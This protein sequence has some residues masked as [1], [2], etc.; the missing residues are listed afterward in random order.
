[1]GLFEQAN[2][3]NPLPERQEELAILVHGTFSD[4]ESDS[5]DQWWQ[6]GSQEFLELQRRLPGNVRIATDQNVFHWSGENSERARSKAAIELLE[7]LRPLERAGRAYHLVG[8]SHGGSVIWNALR[9]TTLSRKQLRGLRSWTTV[10]TPFLHQRGRGPW[11]PINLL[12]VLFGLA[13]VRPAF[14]ALH[15]LSTLLWCTA[16]GREAEIGILSHKDTGFGWL[17]RAP[18]IVLAKWLGVAVEWTDAG[19]RLG[20][21]DPSGDLSPLAYLFTTREGLGVL[22]IT[23]LFIYFFLHMAILSVRPAIES[24]RIRA[25][26][27]LQKRAFRRY[28][29]R[30]LGLW[31]EDDEAINGLRATLDLSMPFVKKLAPAECVFLTDHLLLITRPYYWALAPLFNWIVRPAINALVSGVLIRSAQGNDRP[32]AQVVA[33]LPVPVLKVRKA[34]A[35][36]E[37][38][39]LKILQEADRHAEDVVP[40]LRQLLASPSFTSGWES[41]GSEITGKELVHTSY[42]QHAEV[43]DLI[44]CNVA[45]SVAEQ[46]ATS[47]PMH[48]SRSILRWFRDFKRVVAPDDPRLVQSVNGFPADQPLIMP[49]RRRA[50]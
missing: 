21:F 19:I 14:D 30:W 2:I 42:F 45:W 26:S 36:P 1:M 7:H 35:L 41:F 31:S 17:V 4:D 33:V 38:L 37:I 48:G 43:L 20:G 3:A 28:G 9:M 16:C 10:G 15:H 23:L 39:Q 13:F 34:P 44:S 6:E 32:S 29:P 22:G 25:E 8:H 46:A 12:C 47:I 27:R 11:H 40:K 5:G 18:F 50:A 24:L 49:R